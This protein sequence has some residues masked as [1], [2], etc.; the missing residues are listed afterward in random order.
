MKKIISAIFMAL[1]II[2]SSSCSKQEVD[3]SEAQ[4]ISVKE[5]NLK[6]PAKGGEGTIEFVTESPIEVTVDKEWQSDE[7][8]DCKSRTKARRHC[9]S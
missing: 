7:E 8:P 5:N 9:P 4:T 1:A 2:A 6:I 3:G